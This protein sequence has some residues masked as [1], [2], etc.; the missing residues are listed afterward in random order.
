MELPRALFRDSLRL[1]NLVITSAEKVRVDELIR[2]CKN[3]RHGFRLS[4]RQSCSLEDFTKF[5]KEC[6]HVVVDGLTVEAPESLD[7]E[8]YLK[9]IDYN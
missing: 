1:S 7:I 2:L 5:V 8:E 6:P 3:K 9:S 4:T